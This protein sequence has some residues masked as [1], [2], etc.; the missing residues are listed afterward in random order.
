MSPVTLNARISPMGGMDMLSRQEVSRLRDASHGGLHQLMR[1]CALAV[2]SSGSTADD[3]RAL[4][5]RYPDFD[6]QVHQ[7]DRGIKLELIN[8][9]GEAFVEGEIIRGISELLFAVVRDI[10]YV[11]SDIQSGRF[12]LEESNGI[13]NAVFEILSR[14]HAI[15]GGASLVRAG[16]HLDHL[17]AVIF[18]PR[19]VGALRALREE[20][21]QQAVVRDL[22]QRARRAGER[23]G[24]GL[25]RRGGGLGRRGGGLGRRGGRAWNGEAGDRQVG[26]GD[27]VAVGEDRRA[28]EGVGELADVAGPAGAVEQGARAGVEA[29]GATAERGAGPGEQ[30]L[31]ER[32][33]VLVALAQG[34][35][36]DREHGEAV[37]QVLA[38]AAG[39][40]L[41][42]QVSVGGGD[43]AHVGAQGLAAADALEGPL[44]QH[45]QQLGLQAGRQLADLVEEEGAALGELSAV[46]AHEIRNP[47][48]SLKGHA[49]LLEEQLV[50]EPRRHAKA[51]RVVD[52]AVR[53]ERLTNTLLD[54]ARADRIAPGPASPAEV[55]RRAA[56]LTEPS[57]VVV[58]VTGA[59]ERWTFDAMRVE[60]ALVN[61]VRNALQASA[62]P[63]EVELKV[64]DDGEGLRFTIADRGPGVPSEMRPRLFDPFVT[65]RS[66]G[67]GLGLA[68][69]Q[70]VVRGHGGEIVVRS[71]PGQG[72]TF[73]VVLPAA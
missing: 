7:Q 17:F 72:S 64:A 73:S 37:E 58:D 40:D 34:R 23:L 28:L 36:H 62:A 44:L 63:A 4:L 6:I 31:G 20:L 11:A 13:T 45:A 1:R 67:T 24:G 30:A 54:F 12:N 15:G 19:H 21:R 68:I 53:L 61:L 39:G 10:A 49:Q 52:E 33:D 9:P 66:E 22:R 56:E 32:L 18:D 57:R 55:A 8:A 14:H 71:Q 59:P 48:A 16:L 25:G 50:D 60:Q 41:G 3:P 70:K 43:P 38:E 2:L 46:L 26:G 65:G 69:C 51:Q 5:D 42:R 47:L 27:H 29:Q 35:Q